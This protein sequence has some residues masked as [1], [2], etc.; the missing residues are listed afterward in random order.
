[1][2][3]K[4]VLIGIVFLSFLL[5]P[6]DKLILKSNA[7]TVKV[8]TEE[9]MVDGAQ[10][11]LVGNCTSVRSQWNEE[12]T[13][14]F[15]YITISPRS[16]I[17]GGG[18]DKQIVIKQ[19]GGEVADIG[20]QVE[21]TSVFEEDEEVLLFLKKGPQ[22]YYRIL[23]LN[24]G[25]YSIE[26]DNETGKKVLFKKRAKLIRQSD[27]SIGKKVFRIKT[28]RKLFL[29]DFTYRIQNIIETRTK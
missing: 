22:K 7:T 21:G 2:K 1:M 13:K 3:D 14:I 27:G 19:L 11:I 23:G 5:L 6:S 26:T 8:L 29:D 18:I 25:K 20:M 24:Q 10:D 15:T 4:L 28:D 9:E 17:K 16:F 12:R